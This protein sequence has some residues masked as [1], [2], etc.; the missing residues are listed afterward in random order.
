M[1]SLK[2]IWI[3][4][5]GLALLMCCMFGYAM[6]A[7]GKGPLEFPHEK[8]SI[9]PDY[10]VSRNSNGSVVVTSLKPDDKSVKHVFTDLYADI[11]LAANRKMDVEAMGNLLKKK[12]YLSEDDCRREIKHALNKLSE[13]NIIIREDKMAMH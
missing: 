13:W 7:Y 1:K 3:K 9:N 4:P 12:Y 11:L 5:R 8:I 2:E 10:K 6:S